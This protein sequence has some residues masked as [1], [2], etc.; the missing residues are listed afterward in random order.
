MKVR[1]VIPSL[2]K[3]QATAVDWDHE[4]VRLN[5]EGPVLDAGLDAGNH[6]FRWLLHPSLGLP[7]Q[8][9]MLWRLRTTPQ[10]DP[11]PQEL[12]NRPDWTPIEAVG[13]PVDD[14]WAD[15]GYDL[16]PQGRMG[17]TMPPRDA[18]L[19][20]LRRGAPR[21]GWTSQTS[22]G[23][24]LPAWQPPDLPALVEETCRS[25]LMAGIHAMLR[26]VPLALAHASYL[27]REQDHPARQYPRLLHTDA[28]ALP[29]RNDPAASKWHPLGVLLVGAG[30][31]SWASLTTGFG[32]AVEAE[33][34]DLYMV[35]A[36]HQLTV[37]NAVFN[38]ELA[39]VV[40]VS[41]RLQPPEPPTPV[42]V[43]AQG[44]ERPMRL[45]DVGRQTVEV[46]LATAAESSLRPPAT[47]CRVSSQLRR[48]PPRPRR[49][50][51]RHPAHRAR[52]W[53]LAAVRPQ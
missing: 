21:I 53:R 10:G 36:A 13:L 43:T 50:A 6:Y 19:D 17:N 5:Y 33:E 28:S 20:R 11:S 38:I 29:G 4:R 32:T 47:R 44:F 24:T 46:S 3:L 45:D 23:L 52:R 14:T 15:T 48:R 34:G 9:F 8:P 31:D 7:R 16:S 39:D 26:D 41:D 27:D 1:W 30:S 49:P 18:A 35:T 12:A 2:L 37:G 51:A 40:R 25:R 42:T 22:D